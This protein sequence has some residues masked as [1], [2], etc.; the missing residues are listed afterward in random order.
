MKTSGCFTLRVRSFISPREL[1]SPC[2]PGFL[3]TSFSIL[4]G[5][6]RD[7]SGASSHQTGGVQVSARLW[8]QP[9]TWATSALLQRE[10]AQERACKRWMW[11]ALNRAKA[12]KY[13][14]CHLTERTDKLQ[15]LTE[16]LR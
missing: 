16:M 1:T 9:H 15:R 4:G 8:A 14:L 11:G 7:A 6:S 10:Y 2:P 5:Q 3:L 12:A 13:S